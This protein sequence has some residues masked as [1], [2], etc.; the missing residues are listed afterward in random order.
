MKHKKTMALLLASSIILAYQYPMQSSILANTTEVSAEVTDNQISVGTLVQYEGID[1]KVLSL[2]GT[3]ATVQVGNGEKAVV[4]DKTEIVIPN[5][6]SLGN[7]MFTV[8]E[9]A[10]QA[11]TGFEDEEGNY[12]STVR[13]EKVILPETIT[14]I[15]KKAFFN[16][17]TIRTVE[18]PANSALT[19]IEES[20]FRFSKISSVTL[21]NS[22]EYIG[23]LAFSFSDI[24]SLNFSDDSHLEVIGHMAFANAESLTSISL[25][26]TFDTLGRGAF[27]YTKNLKSITVADENPNFTAK[28]DVLFKKDLSELLIYPAQKEDSQYTTPDGVTSIAPYAFG[29]NE[30]YLKEVTLSEGVEEIGEFAFQRDLKLS[31]ISFPSTL[32]SIKKLAFYDNWALKELI[33]PDS[34]THVNTFAFH[35]LPKLEKLVLGE[36]VTVIPSKLLSGPSET[37]EDI[38]IIEIRTRSKDI[39]IEKEAFDFDRLPS[40]QFIVATEEAKAALLHIGIAS[41]KISIVDTAAPQSSPQTTVTT[42]STTST[43]HSGNIS[44]PKAKEAT[45][46]VYRLYHSGLQVHLYTTDTNERDTLK[47]RGWTY[48]GEAWKTATQAGTPVYRLYHSGLRVHLYTSD[49]NEYKVLATRGWRQEGVAYRSKGDTPVYR[50]YHP[51]IKKHHF[52]KDSNEYKTLA[53]R[54]WK[55]EGIAWYSTQ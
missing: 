48:E 8:T 41:D 47:H 4:S 20:A 26:K 25:P 21:P 38:Q 2:D 29:L 5:V 14:T 43:Q 32:K 39:S 50:L 51:G 33:I 44:S 24:K 11:F 30:N 19:K 53:S 7:L 28:D 37:I 27:S 46:P 54:G 13:A 15:H 18:L 55:Q 40:V 1:Y 31:K 22:L 12:Y 45:Q 36:G 17:K 49:A 34:V 35:K 16:S 9:V 10:E 23:N 42:S 3:N 6:F 52:T